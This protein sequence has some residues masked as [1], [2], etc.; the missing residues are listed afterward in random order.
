MPSRVP[1]AERQYILR[2]AL[3]GRSR[4]EICGVTRRSFGAVNR[5][6]HDYRDD[7]RRIDDD[8]REGHPRSSMQDVDHLIVSAAIDDPLLRSRESGTCLRLISTRA[9]SGGDYVRLAS[10]HVLLLKSRISLID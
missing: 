2:P 10:I 5:I 8:N 3:E 6:I 1:R 4:R 7:G 9:P